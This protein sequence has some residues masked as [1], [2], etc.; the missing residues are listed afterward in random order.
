MQLPPGD[1]RVL[2]IIAYYGNFFSLIT[3]AAPIGGRS[4]GRRRGVG[5]AGGLLEAGATPGGVPVHTRGLVGTVERPP[6]RHVD[7]RT[8]AQK[9]D[10][11]L[12]GA[13]SYQPGG[14]SLSWV[15]QLW[16]YLIIYLTSC[17]VS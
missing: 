1:S 16:W 9:T 11:L 7:P 3:K 15:S 10:E 14:K 12:H 17:Q 5:V 4:G 6:T 2:I 8:L 13:L